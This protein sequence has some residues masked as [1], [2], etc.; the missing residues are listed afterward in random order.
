MDTGITKL[1]RFEAF[2]ADITRFVDKIT[3]TKSYQLSFPTAMSRTNKLDQYSGVRLYWN[4][5]DKQIGIEFLKDRPDGT[6][7]LI[8]SG[9]F[10]SYIVAKGFFILNKLDPKKLA[11]K[12]EYKRHSLKKLGADRP[13]VMFVIDLKS[14]EVVD[15]KKNI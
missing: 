7:K 5:A 8:K 3:I 1:G 2:N 4:K 9:N 14:R 11:Y 6:F 12:Y 15:G 13:G 10:G